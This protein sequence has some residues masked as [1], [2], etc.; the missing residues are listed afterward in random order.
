[1]QTGVSAA[2]L[3]TVLLV[4]EPIVPGGIGIYTSNIMEGLTSAGVTHPAVTS[5]PPVLGLLPEAELE[6]FEIQD[7]L[8]KPL[9]WPLIRGKLVSWAQQQDVKLIH[10]LS[11]VTQPLCAKLAARLKLPYVLTVHHFQRKGSIVPDPQLKAV[12]TVSDALREHLVNDAGVPKELVRLIPA[13]IRVPETLHARPVEYS[14][15]AESSVPLVSCF[16]KLVPRKD[17]ACFLRAARRVLDTLGHE[18]SFVLAGDGPEEPALRKLA[19]ELKLERHVTF[20][21]G[22]IRYDELLRDTD[23]YVQC[24][25]VEG[26]GTMVLQA[27]AHGLPAVATA[28][29]GLLSLVQRASW[30]PSAITRLWR[31][32]SSIC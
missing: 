31:R 15:D 2:E 8:F 24:S 9:W 6:H 14:Q 19:K 20:C 7:S 18:C 28:T 12:V 30:F 4:S 17:C 5:H 25:K 16:S 23:V 13:G 11:A 26:F 22:A 1:V 27:M 21:H 29:G 32:A 10:G 3:G